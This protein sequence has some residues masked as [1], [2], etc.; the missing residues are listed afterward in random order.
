MVNL[1]VTIMFK[2]NVPVTAVNSENM[3]L[4]NHNNDIIMAQLLYYCLDYFDI[5]THDDFIYC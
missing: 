3:Q 1:H 4:A 5:K 2:F